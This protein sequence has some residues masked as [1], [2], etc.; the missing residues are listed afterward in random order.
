[1]DWVWP[2]RVAPAPSPCAGAT[3]GAGL[4][5]HTLSRALCDNVQ[6]LAIPLVDPRVGAILCGLKRE[7]LRGQCVAPLS[8]FVCGAG[9]RGSISFCVNFVPPAF[10]GSFFA[11]QISCLCFS[12]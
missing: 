5:Q 8:R 4:R 6:I 12:A 10:F 1:V 7:Q 3:V 11:P 9:R 2:D